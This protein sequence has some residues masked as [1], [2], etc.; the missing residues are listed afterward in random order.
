MKKRGGL[1]GGELG[2]VRQREGETQGQREREERPK[3]RLRG[4]EGEIQGQRAETQ[5]QREQI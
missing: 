2:R 4:R 1:R 5:G 3:G